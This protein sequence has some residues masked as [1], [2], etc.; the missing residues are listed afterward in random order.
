[1][2]NH[3][4][5]A[6][7]RSQ[8]AATIGVEGVTIRGVLYSIEDKPSRARKKE[9]FGG[10]LLDDAGEVW[11]LRF[12]QEH[13]D[14]ARDLWRKAVEL[15]GNARHSRTRGPVLHVDTGKVIDAPDWQKALVRYRGAWRDVYRGRSFEQIVSDLR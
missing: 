3:E 13:V 14:L 9:T 12:G 4:L 11:T 15:S 7:L 10:R 8:Q 6:R 1:V 2:R 5:R